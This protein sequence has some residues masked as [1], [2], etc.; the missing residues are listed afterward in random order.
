MH[1]Q[2]P[3]L[4]DPMG[5]FLSP[6]FGSFVAS[7]S[8]V[9][10][11]RP[12]WGHWGHWGQPS[13]CLAKSHWLWANHYILLLQH[14][15]CLPLRLGLFST[16]M[17]YKLP[18]PIQD[19][20]TKTYM[21]SLLCYPLLQRLTWSLVYF[22]SSLKAYLMP[23]FAHCTLLLAYM[24]PFTSYLVEYCIIVYYTSSRLY[25]WWIKGFCYEVWSPS[26]STSQ[27]MHPHSLFYP[28]G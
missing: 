8:W 3:H 12:P 17:A 4:M 1:V 21:K 2:G 5:T 22:I 24:M 23:Y 15:C 18:F 14:G 16:A 20:S 25:W 19:A 13:A 27:P 11:S 6:V 9:S 7:H 26:T 10:P 28:Q